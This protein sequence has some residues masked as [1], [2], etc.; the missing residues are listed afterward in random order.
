MKLL[1]FDIDGT[2]MKS[3]RAGM[4]AADRAF[5]KLFGIGNAMDGIRT[6][7]LTDP[8]I[9]RMMF[10]KVFDREFSN[11]ESTSFYNEYINFLDLELKTL[12]EIDVLPGVVDL[13]EELIGR[14]DCVLALGTGNIEEGAWIKL[15]YAGLSSYFDTGGFG[16]DSEKR[17][18]LLVIGIKK[19][20]E[21]YNAGAN[22]SDIYVI[23]D[24]PHDVM[25]GKAAGAKTV[26]VAT[27]SYSIDE[28]RNT[29]PD[30]LLP[31]LGDT[32]IISL[33]F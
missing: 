32:N 11:E 23:G 9:L 14:D 5:E 1:L 13:L 7:G 16:S 10:K 3:F 31:D 30:Y 4:R 19:A 17:N 33:I 15:R 18:E 6:D 25:H 8:L 2:L 12:D 29:E 27:G 20:S 28:L 22:F 21:T 26:G 24:T